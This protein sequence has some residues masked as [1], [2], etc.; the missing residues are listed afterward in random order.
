MEDKVKEQVKH[1]SH[2]NKG[3]FIENIK[4]LFKNPPPVNSIIE[5]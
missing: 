5:A 4:P 2:Y 1:P 3:K